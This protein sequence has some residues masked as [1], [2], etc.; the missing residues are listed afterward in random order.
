MLYY[1]ME[2]YGAL[3]GR[4]EDYRKLRPVR[5]IV[6]TEF[7]VFPE[8]KELHTVFEIRAR[9]NPQVL[10]SQHFQ[11]HVLR[12]GDLLRNNLLGLDQFCLELQRWVQFWVFGAK[13]E[14]TKMSTML[15]DCPP[16]Q[17]AYEELKRFS[18]DSVMREK[19]RARQRFLDEQMII[20]NDVRE[21]GEAIGE[22][23]GEAR[24]RAE[25][26]RETAAIMKR[27][28]FGSAVIAKITGLPLAEI[29]RL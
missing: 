11:M 20:M 23:R 14:D 24:G 15:Q 25:K 18:S 4:G 12:L 28:G 29:E 22:A 27:E 3:L 6:I 8:L 19:A 10:L 1:W 13:L 17:A 16:V 5:S 26:A 9:E 2:T 7:P 21:E